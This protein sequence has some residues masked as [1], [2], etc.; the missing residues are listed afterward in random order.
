MDKK[1]YGFLRKD[2]SKIF[3]YSFL[4]FVVDFTCAY[5]M[6]ACVIGT[7]EW[8]LALLLYNFCAFAMQMPM[9]V[10]AD[11]KG[12]ITQFAALGCLLLPI[13]YIF[14]KNPLILA[15]IAGVGNGF[16]HVGAGV[17]VLSM[18]EK[19]A[20]ALGIFVS[21]G[22]L[23]IYLGTLCGKQDLKGVIPLLIMVAIMGGILFYL[24]RYWYTEDE[25]TEEST[26]PVEHNRVIEI[27]MSVTCLFL[28]VVIRSFAGMHFNFPWKETASEAVGFILVMGVVLGKMTGGILADKIGIRLATILSLGAATICFL[29]SDLT[30]MGIFAVFFF[31][32]TMPIT[33]W[34]VAKFLWRW[35]GFSFGLLTFALFLGFIP[36]YL[37]YGSMFAN[38]YGYIGMTIVSLL[39]MLCCLI[40]KKDFLNKKM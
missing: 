28:V 10:L 30:F 32:M 24:V 11:A 8:R 14:G 15:V 36:S 37:G 31:N 20:S 2:G 23:G 40:G 6:F 39:L 12:G 38:I 21:P 34:L 17:D 5:L 13:G 26:N 1:R 3:I 4:H 18:S 35:R 29:F 19:K 16:Y 25:V 33:L 7:K 22:A 27:V 9:G